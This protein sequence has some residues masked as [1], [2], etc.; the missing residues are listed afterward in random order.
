MCENILLFYGLQK[1]LSELESTDSHHDI[2]SKVKQVNERATLFRITS[3]A[4]INVSF[5]VLFNR[6]IPLLVL[7]F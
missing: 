2:V 5:A 6:V 7:V 3:T 1:A 4:M